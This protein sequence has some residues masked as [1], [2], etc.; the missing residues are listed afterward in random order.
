MVVNKAQKAVKKKITQ[1]SWVLDPETLAALK[2]CPECKE[3]PAVFLTSK[4]VPCCRL[5]WE[6]IADGINF[7]TVEMA[8]PKVEDFVDFEETTAK[9]SLSD[10]CNIKVT[11]NEEA[12]KFGFD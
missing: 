4:K 11:K 10:C 8:V 12:A 6:K 1:I 9:Y 5:C 2:A 3:N 7:A